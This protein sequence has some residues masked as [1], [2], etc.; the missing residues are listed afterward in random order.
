MVVILKTSRAAPVL[1]IKYWKIC[2]YRFQVAMR[3]FPRTQW[4]MLS[5]VLSWIR[6]SKLIRSVNLQSFQI[7][8]Q[9]RMKWGGSKLFKHFLQFAVL[10]M[11]LFIS[12]SRISDNKHHWSDVLAGL[13]VGV[14]VA[15]LVTNFI[16]GLG[17]P[18]PRKYLLEPGYQSR[19][20]LSAAV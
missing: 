17:R 18:E 1:T 15:L 4:F 3:V 13:F 19:P 20:Q 16:A 9:I 5:W 14:A 7:Y 6:P 10:M 12:L 2:G 8:L 11:A